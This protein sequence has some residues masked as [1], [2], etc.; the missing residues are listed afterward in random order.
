MVQ[1]V[2]SLTVQAASADKFSFT[3]NRP[4]PCGGW[5]IYPK[6]AIYGP[7]M[8]QMYNWLV[9]SGFMFGEDPELRMARSQLHL[10]DM[11]RSKI[12]A[13]IRDYVI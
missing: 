2:V 9:R 6:F 1:R 8:A 4:M 5:E 12:N 13:R 3:F 11:A 10:G 7:H